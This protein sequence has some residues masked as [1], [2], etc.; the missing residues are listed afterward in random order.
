[1]TFADEEAFEAL[2][3]PPNP[4]W[5]VGRTRGCVPCCETGRDAD[6]ECRFCAG[7]GFIPGALFGWDE[8]YDE[9]QR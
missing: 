9:V 5:F 4:E 6:G 8:D 1:M 7:L 2:L 3:P